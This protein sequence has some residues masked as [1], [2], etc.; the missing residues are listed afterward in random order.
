VI[1]CIITDCF[2]W[3]LTMDLK[4]Y[5]VCAVPSEHMLCSFIF[6]HRNKLHLIRRCA[7]LLYSFHLY[8][9]L[10][11]SSVNDCWSVTA[12]SIVVIFYVFQL[13]SFGI[14]LPVC[15]SICDHVYLLEFCCCFAFNTYTVIIIAIMTTSYSAQR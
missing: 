14:A 1:N 8:I 4:L 2:N 7:I 5:L 15:L 6:I 3:C 11:F 13:T 10:Y 9:L 12:N